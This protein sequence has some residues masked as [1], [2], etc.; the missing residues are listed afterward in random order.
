MLRILFLLSLLSLSRTT[1]LTIWQ[2]ENKNGASLTFTEPVWNFV[3]FGWN[4]VVTSVESSGDWELYTDAGF[5]G[6]RFT[7]KDGRTV[8]N[9]GG[10][11]NDEF[12]SARPTCEYFGDDGSAR[13]TLWEDENQQ[14]SQ[15]FFSKDTNYFGDD[16][17]DKISSVCADKSNWELYKDADFQGYRWTVNEGQCINV[18]HNDEYSSA[19]P[20]C[21][22]YKPRCKVKKIT[23]HDQGQLTPRLEDTEVVGSADG[24]S[25]Y[26]PSQKTLIITS[27]RSISESTTL[28]VSESNEVN[29]GTTVSVTVE[30]SAEF[31]GS[32]STVSFGVEVSS[33]GSRT[34][35]Q[36]ESKTL[37]VGSESLV[38]MNDQFAT[39]GAGIVFGLVEKYSIDGSNTPA[40]MEMECPDG[41]TYTEPTTMKVKAT[42]YSSA[43]FWSLVGAF[44]P[45][46][47]RQDPLLTECV[48]HV[49]K[50]YSHFIGRKEDVVADFNECFADGKG[51]VSVRNVRK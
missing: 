29:W 20:I 42:T 26:G 50:R 12:S 38:G 44:N 17:N 32:G 1:W 5:Q 40:T 2:H 41:S 34:V 48:R 47:C 22:S 24:G 25:C 23:V 10:G 9:V 35:S 16:W 11:F 33:G 45:S 19:R 49:R 13:L 27:A 46:A 36:S 39:P 3:D 8:N 7:V 28:E 6:K 43:H 18:G 15:T 14:G 4:D 37:E 21:S 30:A 51:T 31:L